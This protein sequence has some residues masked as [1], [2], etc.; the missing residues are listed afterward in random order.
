M[1]TTILVTIGILAG[2]LYFTYGFI[3]LRAANFEAVLGR[4]IANTTGEIICGI[5]GVK[6]SPLRV[7][8]FKNLLKNCY[9]FFLWPVDAYLTSGYLAKRGM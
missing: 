2:L 4:A 7:K 9:I 3:Y 6:Y 5:V 1:T 8:R